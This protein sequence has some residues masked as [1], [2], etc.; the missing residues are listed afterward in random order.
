MDGSSR[1]NLLFPVGD[2]GPAPLNES[3]ASLRLGPV[4]AALDVVVPN[5]PRWPEIE[6]FRPL[7]ATVTLPSFVVACGGFRGEF[8]DV[9]N[10]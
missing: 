1:K 6:V 10:A 8:T 4:R 7:P 3:L 2:R 9:A 5:E